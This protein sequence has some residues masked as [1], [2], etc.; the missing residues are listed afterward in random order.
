[1]TFKRQP[2]E[3]ASAIA[4][5]TNPNQFD[6][7]QFRLDFDAPK[8][9]VTHNVASREK[10]VP[11]NKRAGSKRVPLNLRTLEGALLVIRNLGYTYVVE[12]AGDTS[13][14]YKHGTLTSI[15]AVKPTKEAKKKKASRYP[16]GYLK[17]YVEPQV[18]N[19]KVSELLEL[20]SQHPDGTSISLYS[21]QSS[22]CNVAGRLWGFGSVTTSMNPKNKTVEVLRLT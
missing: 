11:S 18:R 3:L 5:L 8:K 20:S 15:E 19:M 2:R 6:T 17:K 1:M 9:R 10:G 16:S 12:K 4:E 13:E 7:N 22:V 21:L 14:V